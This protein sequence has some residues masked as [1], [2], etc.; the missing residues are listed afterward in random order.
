MNKTHSHSSLLLIP[1]PFSADLPS[2]SPTLSTAQTQTKQAALSTIF[3]N[4]RRI[5]GWSFDDLARL[6]LIK[7]SATR[8]WHHHHSNIKIIRLE[9]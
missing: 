7:N 6:K 1:L 4:M 5:P 2:L 9:N 3:E 8:H